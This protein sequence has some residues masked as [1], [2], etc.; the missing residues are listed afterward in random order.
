MSKTAGLTPNE[1][2]CIYKR[3]GR[4]AVSPIVEILIN[5]IRQE[6]LNWNIKLPP[7][8]YRQKID[9]SSGKIRRIGIQNVKQQLYDYIAVEALQPVLKR[10]GEHQYASL[11]GKG[12]LKGA[13]QIRRW[14]QNKKITVVAK[15]DVKKCYESIDREK[16]MQFLQKYVKN[17]SLLKL[18][19]ILIYTF[20]SGLSIGSYLSQYLR[21]LYMSELYHEIQERMHHTR[22]HKD[23]TVERRRLVKKTLIYM[24]DIFL[25]GT[26]YKYIKMAMRRIIKKCSE[27]GLTIKP[28][29]RI[30]KIKD[31]F[32]D[33]MGYRVYRTKMTIRRSIFLRIRRAYVLL[34]KL[35][36]TH[37]TIPRAL[38][39]RCS[40]YYGYLKHTN[41]RNIQKQLK[42]KRALRICRRVING[43]RT[44]YYA[45]TAGQNL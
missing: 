28:T 15:A 35:H 19:R 5:Q 23:G 30:W 45:A 29:Y 4:H 44:V 12:T 22:R 40:S 6:I 34:T 39:K 18:I 9:G 16:L 41:S 20:E 3:G 24:D 33:M 38:A 32:V 26:N 27:L 37:K 8:W 2:Y 17:D 13:R 21:N 10:I 36:E 43:K 14:L 1:V 7:L 42:V 31:T 25:C 11:K